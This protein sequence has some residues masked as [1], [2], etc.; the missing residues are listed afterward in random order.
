MS[1]KISGTSDSWSKKKRSNGHNGLD[2][3]QWLEIGVRSGWVSPPVCYTHDGLPTS[4]TEDAEFEDGS[5]P[6]IH[7]M[8]C[9]ES[10]AHKEAIELNYAPAIWRNN[11][12]D[13][14]L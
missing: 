14:E 10:Q 5:D 2:F 3:D 12:R 7:V 8:R 4:V 13:E 6:C 1:K 11:Y 9:Y